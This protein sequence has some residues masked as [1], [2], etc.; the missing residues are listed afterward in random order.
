MSGS[1]VFDDRNCQRRD[2]VVRRAVAFVDSCAE[3]RTARDPHA[4]VLDVAADPQVF[5]T[6]L[7][8]CSDF[9]HVPRTIA[10]TSGCRQ[11]VVHVYI[12]ASPRSGQ[13]IDCWLA[14]DRLS[15]VQRGVAGPHTS[16]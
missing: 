15:G 14:H 9:G 16:P 11:T 10:S 1:L 4:A 5:Q 13:A 6:R 2:E 3:R 12:R 7:P 8:C